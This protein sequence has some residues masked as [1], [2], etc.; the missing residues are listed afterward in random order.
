MFNSCLWEMNGKYV[1]ML[2]VYLQDARDA[3][4]ITLSCTTDSKVCDLCD[5]EMDTEIIEIFI[6]PA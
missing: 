6:M 2:S 1:L 4:P 5:L 3:L